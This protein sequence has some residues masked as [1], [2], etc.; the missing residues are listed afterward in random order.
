MDN[1]WQRPKEHSQSLLHYSTHIE[2]R[3]QNNSLTGHHAKDTLIGSLICKRA[4]Q[5]LSL[6]RKHR[7]HVLKKVLQILKKFHDIIKIPS[8]LL[9][10]WNLLNYC[11]NNFNEVILSTGMST[12]AE[13][14]EAINKTREILEIINRRIEEETKWI[15]NTGRRI[16]WGRRAVL[17][18]LKNELLKGNDPNLC[19]ECG[20]K[21]FRTWGNKEEY[22]Y[23]T[24]HNNDCPYI[25]RL[26]KLEV[27]V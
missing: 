7:G 18:E 1:L 10:N 9:T 14:E 13:I 25:K 17:K 19:K 21:S 15:D 20:S 3:L 23:M 2:A 6:G 27:K 22:G 24:L 12:E 5:V 4:V 26:M 16:Y 8:A 11:R